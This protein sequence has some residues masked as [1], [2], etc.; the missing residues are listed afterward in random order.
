MHRTGIKHIVRHMQ[1]SV[2]Q[3]SVISKF[4]CI[5]F[6]EKKIIMT[7]SIMLLLLPHLSQKALGIF[8]WKF[9]RNLLSDKG[10]HK[11]CF[12]KTLCCW[13]IIWPIQNDAKKLK[14]TKTLTNGYSSKS[15]QRELSNKYQHDRVWV[16]FG[17][18][19]Y[20]CAFDKS[21]PCIGRVK[22]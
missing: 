6:S 5:K 7:K 20:P 2:V 9:W 1:K 17:N 21:S 18:I 4:A 16:V 14:M 3:W 15:T 22:Y 12:F 10:T 13:W 8:K 11:R 19:L